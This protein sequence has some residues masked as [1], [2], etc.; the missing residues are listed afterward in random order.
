MGEIPGISIGAGFCGNEFFHVDVFDG[1][2]AGW[3]GEKKVTLGELKLT[4]QGLGVSSTQV[5]PIPSS[6]C[7]PVG[8]RNLP[9]CAQVGHLQLCEGDGELGTNQYLNNCGG[10]DIYTKFEAG[11]GCST[12]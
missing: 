10:W 8:A 11:K 4:A 3:S 6:L 1:F 9:N 2:S 12:C 7:P 5:T